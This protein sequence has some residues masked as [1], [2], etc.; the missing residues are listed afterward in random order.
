MLKVGGL[1]LDFPVVQ[2]ALSGYS[3]VAMRRIARRHGA[4]L[5]FDQAVLDQI[6]L[7]PG[8]HQRRLLR[9]APDDRPIGGQLMGS[10]PETIARASDAMAQAGYDVIDINLACPVRKVLGRGRGGFL[11]S[12]PQRA[13]QIVRAVHGA[14]A[15]RCPVAI[16]VRRGWDDSAESERHFFEILDGA[17]EAD[18]DAAI[19]HPGTVEQ[20]YVGPS[21]WEF[22][23]RVKRHVGD[24]VVLG[25]GDLFTARDVGRMLDETGVDGV[26]LAR[27]CIGNP[28]LFGEC[29]ALL[30]GEPIPPPPSVPE[31]GCTIGQHLAWSLEVHGER[32]GSRIMRKFGIKYSELHPH[33][34]QVRDAIVRVSNASQW[35]A[36]LDEWYDPKKDW[37]PP[38]RRTGPD[39]LVAAGATNK[40]AQS[41]DPS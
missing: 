7:T 24:R 1:E 19:V 20:R 2:A 3:D 35:Q 14:V 25:T 5:T 16:K 4:V 11:L 9:V 26:T 32:R 36:V 29:R 33:H 17:F 40:T 23:G 22:L 13:L 41:A 34:T 21:R 18:V 8:T 37:P 27:G 30:A 10:D 39:H 28:W 38:T 6:V 15:G 12:Q 31:Q